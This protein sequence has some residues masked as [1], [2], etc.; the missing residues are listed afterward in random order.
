MGN[1]RTLK[2]IILEDNRF[3]LELVLFEL[4]R[5]GYSFDWTQVDCEAD[6]RQQIENSPDIILADYTLPQF[7]AMRALH[8]LQE[9]SLDI[10]FVV[11]T[12]SISEEVAVECMKQGASDYLIKDRLSRLGQVIERAFEQKSL[13]DEKRRSEQA[14]RASEDKFSKTF[15]LLPDAMSIH[16]ASTGVFLEVNQG[17]SK[18]LGY[19]MD[20]V[21]GSRA[22]E[23]AIWVNQE[24]QKNILAG[25]REHGEVLDV[26]TIF[27]RK[28]GSTIYGSISARRIE[29]DGTPA[30]LSIMR[31]V[32]ERK[33][34]E[35]ELKHAHDEL[36]EAYDATIEGWALAMELR[37]SE[38]EGHSRRVTSLTIKLAELFGLSQDEITKIRRGVLL[39][40]I[41]KMAITD[42]I[43]QKN[44]PLTEDEWAVMRKHPTHAYRMLSSIAYLQPSL[45]IPY[46]HHEHWD[47]SGY[48]RGLKGEEI[49]LSARLFSVV[50]VW[51][52]LR[53]DRPYR[54]AVSPEEAVE[55]I[56]SQSG[57]YFDPKVVDLFL[58]L[59]AEGEL[60]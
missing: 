56:R 13:R 51:D 35:E 41:G 15:H 3:D 34:A 45:D 20:E 18:I 52:A 40:D 5:A 23:L 30:I 53:S 21:I 33:L 46:C 28:N 59:I 7:D 36:E 19:R 43:L 9:H 47:G 2:I 44:G 26:E 39:H 49:P 1:P 22:L 25:L 4:R 17:F 42:R 55:Y 27:R 16:D 54:A 31:D 58:R 38:T 50:D 14:L 10:P 37:D 24:D 48:P 11:V 29:F 6:Y 12:G 32:T 8:I 60:Y 57:L